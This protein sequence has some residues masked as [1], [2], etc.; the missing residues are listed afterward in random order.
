VPQDQLQALGGLRRGGGPPLPRL[1][2]LVVVAVVVVLGQRRRVQ[3]R[4]R[5]APRR[6]RGPHEPPRARVHQGLAEL[7]R[8][9]ADHA[10]CHGFDL[11]RHAVGQDDDVVV[12]AP[13]LGQQE[14]AVEDAVLG[15]R[16]HDVRELEAPRG[17]QASRGEQCHRVEGAGADLDFF[18]DALR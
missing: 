7:P 13:E 15:F 14:R 1:E 12:A 18:V 11:E 10:L 17:E 5:R 6:A 3:A 16:G 9:L 4:P 8:P 2:V